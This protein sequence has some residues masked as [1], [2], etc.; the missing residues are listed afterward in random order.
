[1]N[2]LLQ[3]LRLNPTDRVF[4]VA[5]LRKSDD[6]EVCHWPEERACQQKLMTDTFGMPINASSKDYNTALSRAIGGD[7]A[8]AWLNSVSTPIMSSTSYKRRADDLFSELY[9]L[10]DPGFTQ[11]SGSLSA[12][13][14]FVSSYIP[15]DEAALDEMTLQSQPNL[16]RGFR[17]MGFN[18]TN[19]LAWTFDFRERR[20]LQPSSFNPIKIGS[21]QA[22]NI[23]L[24]H[25]LLIQRSGMSIIFLCGPD[26]EL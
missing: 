21:R 11:P 26:A 9:K 6:P 2:P 20:Q 23:A 18:E 12:R 7:G 25:Q 13:I 10:L 17:D 1:M 22:K 5:Q 8:K 15:D 14:G 4:W 3:S 16:H 24:C 19:S